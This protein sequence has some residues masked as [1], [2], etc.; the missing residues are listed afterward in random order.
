MPN[1]A[2]TALYV[3]MYAMWILSLE[4]TSMDVERWFTVSVLI[5]VCAQ[6]PEVVQPTEQVA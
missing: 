3:P 5:V 2:Y 1:F 6:L 4:S